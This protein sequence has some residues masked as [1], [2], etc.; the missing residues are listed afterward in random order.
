MSET[1]TTVL[2]GRC[3]DYINIQTNIT[4]EEKIKICILIQI[5]RVKSRI[6]FILGWN[7]QV[8]D[9]YA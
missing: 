4:K 3:N 1:Y 2:C 6:W 8:Y 7:F 9:R 5:L